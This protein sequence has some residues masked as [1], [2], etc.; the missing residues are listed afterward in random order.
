[1]D[2]IPQR[3]AS[4][5]IWKLALLAAAAGAL[6]VLAMAPFFAW[7]VLFVT[8]PVLIWVLDAIC[9]KERPGKNPIQSFRKKLLGA[10]FIGWAFGFGYFL[11]SIYWIGYAFFVDADRYAFLMPFAV[12]ALPAGLALFYAAAAMLWAVMWQRGYPRILAFA[13]AF[14]LAEAARGYILTGFPWNLFGQ[15]LAASDA[16]MQAAAYIGVYGLTLEALFVFSAG[17]AFIALPAARHGR[18]AAPAVCAAIVLAASYALGLYRLQDSAGGAEGVRVR[19]VQP[20]IPQREKWKPEN[21]RWIFERMLNLSRNGSDGTD[22]GGFTHVIWPED[23]V[24]FL[25]VLNREIVSGEAR[26]VLASLVPAQTKLV[27]GAERA[28]GSRASDG[29]F[30]FDRV[31]NSLFTISAGAQIVGAYD[32]SHLVPFGEYVPFGETLRKL[33]LRPFSHRLDGFDAGREPRSVMG[34]PGGPAFTPL[35]CYEIIFPGLVVD[36]HNRP[37]WLINIT[38]DAWFG[39]S[40]GPYQHLQ[41]ARL[42]ATEEGLPVM[43]SANTGISAVID[44]FG[45]ILAKLGLGK[46][47]VLDHALPRSLPKTFYAKTRLPAFIVLFLF[48]LQLYLVMVSKIIDGRFWF[49]VFGTRR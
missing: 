8:F 42:R 47:G 3:I 7:P 41:Q 20:N 25:F 24:P 45:R 15:A 37:D 44:P 39:D 36:E 2:S 4:L 33:G 16:Q 28:E 38:N 6:S 21:Q 34:G 40:T 12:A 14:F 13:F 19:I 31:F 18:L 48:P 26:E 22:I 1:M 9:L 32:K 11:A 23:T 30:S 46:T 10:G 5:K 43:R 35:I 17:A 49:R 29:R 27:I